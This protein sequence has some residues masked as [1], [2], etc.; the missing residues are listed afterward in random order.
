MLVA[1]VIQINV[2]VPSDINPGSSTPVE[3]TVGAQ[4]SKSGVTVATR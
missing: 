1:G 4:T 2:E 3:V